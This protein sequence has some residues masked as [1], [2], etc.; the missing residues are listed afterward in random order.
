MSA[1]IKDLE[2]MVILYF[3]RTTL[4]SKTKISTSVYKK[5]AGNLKETL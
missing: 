3:N 2:L 4:E 5:F 1:K